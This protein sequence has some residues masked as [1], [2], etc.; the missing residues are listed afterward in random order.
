MITHLI[1]L[2]FSKSN[3]WIQYFIHHLSLVSRS[4]LTDLAEGWFLGYNAPS[5]WPSLSATFI[6]D[7]GLGSQTRNTICRQSHH[8][9]I[10]PAQ[11]LQFA[12][13]HMV[14]SLSLYYGIML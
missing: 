5:H 8:K 12:D 3:P 7:S 2:R 1:C 11:F 6:R 10:L 14:V 4:G 9:S 13:S